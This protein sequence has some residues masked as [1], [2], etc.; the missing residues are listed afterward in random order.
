M[1]GVNRNHIL[2][3]THK[4]CSPIQMFHAHWRGDPKAVR[5]FLL[6]TYGIHLYN[7][8]GKPTMIEIVDQEKAAMFK[9]AWA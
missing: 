5:D 8:N 4:L 3:E 6:D 9:L 2:L 7:P 1:T